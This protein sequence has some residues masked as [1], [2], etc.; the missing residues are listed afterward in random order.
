MYVRTCESLTYSLTFINTD[1]T[2]HLM[3]QSNNNNTTCNN[4]HNNLTR[5]RPGTEK[6]MSVGITII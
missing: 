6:E 5:T 4:P 2:Y 3:P 1:S